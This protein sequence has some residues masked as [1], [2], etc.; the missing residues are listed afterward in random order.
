MTRR[1]DATG[2]KGMGIFEVGRPSQLHLNEASSI[3]VMCAVRIEALQTLP[4]ALP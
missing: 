2:D 3:E 4:L 1:C